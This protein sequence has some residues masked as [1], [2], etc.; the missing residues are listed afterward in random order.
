MRSWQWLV[1]SFTCELVRW[2]LTHTIE[3][4]QQL[5][6]IAAALG[7]RGVFSTSHSTVRSLSECECETRGERGRER[8]QVCVRERERGGGV[9]K[10]GIG[11]LLNCPF[12]CKQ[13]HT[14]TRN[15]S[16]SLSLEL[17]TP[18][19]LS[20]DLS[21]PLSTSTYP[22]VTCESSSVHCCA[23]SIVLGMDIHAMLQQC[24]HDGCGP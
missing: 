21:R 18:L 11:A 8:E 2:T 9:L 14:H 12:L 3:K 17:S 23:A 15:R 4:Q 16:P 22:S 13:G 10:H 7:R 6:L 19:S 24:V 1:C 20:L 5:F